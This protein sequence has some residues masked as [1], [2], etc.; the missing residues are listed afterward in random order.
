M[1]DK[2][3]ELNSTKNYTPRTAALMKDYQQVW[4]RQQD[5]AQNEDE[6]ES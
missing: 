1:D 5:E 4:Q 2:E 6:F 3:K